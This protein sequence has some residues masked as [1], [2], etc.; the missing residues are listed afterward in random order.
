MYCAAT[1]YHSWPQRLLDEYSKL[2][3]VVIACSTQSPAE[4]RNGLV[5]RAQEQSKL[6]ITYPVMSDP[7]ELVTAPFGAKSPLGGTS[8]QTFIIDPSGVRRA[9][10][11]KVGTMRCNDNAARRCIPRV[12]SLGIRVV[13]R[14]ASLIFR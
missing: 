6:A 7:K 8:R 2:D 1:P 11:E 14:R 5:R 4:Q 3:A 13:R 9:R 10:L 12:G